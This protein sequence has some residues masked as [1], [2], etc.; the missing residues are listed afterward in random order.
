MPRRVGAWRPAW[1][2]GGDPVEY[3]AF[4]TGCVGDSYDI[5]GE[6]FFGPSIRD[7]DRFAVTVEDG[8]IVVDTSRICGAADPRCT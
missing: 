2:S 3:G 4:R 6:R 1:R 7:L 8:V 5:H